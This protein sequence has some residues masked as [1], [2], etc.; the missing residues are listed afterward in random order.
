MGGMGG[1]G[2]QMNGGP[3]GRRFGE[4]AGTVT[5]TAPSE[6]FPSEGQMTPPMRQGGA[7]NAEMPELPEDFDPSNMPEPP[8]DFDPSAN[9]PS[10]EMPEGFDPSGMPT[11]GEL[12]ELPEGNEGFPAP[13]TSGFAPTGRGGRR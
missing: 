10:G 2:G 3:G 8:A 7:E 6:S 12:P 11:P 13:P 5:E 9:M 1:P 4:S